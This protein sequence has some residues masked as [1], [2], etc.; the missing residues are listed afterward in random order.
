MICGENGEKLK[1]KAPD[2][3]QNIIHVQG[4]NDGTHTRA[5]LDQSLQISFEIPNFPLVQSR[6]NFGFSF[7][8]GPVGLGL[9]GHVDKMS[10]VMNSMFDL[11]YGMTSQE[12]TRSSSD[13]GELCLKKVVPPRANGLFQFFL[14][15]DPKHGHAMDL[16]SCM[17]SDEK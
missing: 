16:T 15:R 3:I 12:E 17:R 1:Q 11:E 13:N 6:E 14:T 8:N 4:P 5:G 2:D 7:G 10:M 9:F